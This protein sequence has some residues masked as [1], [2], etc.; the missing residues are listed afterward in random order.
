MCWHFV[1]HHWNEHLKAGTQRIQDNTSALIYHKECWQWILRASYQALQAG[2]IWSFLHSSQC[3]IPRFWILKNITW[4]WTMKNQR[5]KSRLVINAFL[6]PAFLHSFQVIKFT[7]PTGKMR[8]G[9]TPQ[10]SN[11]LFKNLFGSLCIFKCFQAH[12][13]QNGK[14]EQ[15]STITFC[16]GWSQSIIGNSGA[17]WSYTE[18]NLYFI[19]FHSR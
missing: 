13:A 2:I 9:T 11:L 10:I 18:Y 12:M 15:N 19:S 17:Q 8:H 3:L 5:W 16:E 6:F 14:A 4:F 1:F 7:I